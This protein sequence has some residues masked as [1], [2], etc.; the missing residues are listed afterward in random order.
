[1]M[2]CP[3][4]FN[5][6]FQELLNIPGPSMVS[7][8]ST[9]TSDLT[10]MVCQR[11][12]LVCA[13][14]M[15]TMSLS[16]FYKEDYSFNT[17]NNGEEYI[18]ITEDSAKGRAELLIDS[19]LSPN[20]D[21]AEA[22][23]VLEIGCGKGSFMR[24]L[25]DRFPH[26]QIWG[27]E[28]S[29]KASQLATTAGLQVVN[30]FLDE[31][32]L[33]GYQFDIVLAVGVLEHIPKP[34]IFLKNCARLCRSGGQV[35]IMI[36][37]SARISYDIFFV[38]HLFHFAPF[39][40]ATFMERAD[41]PVEV[42]MTDEPPVP[43]FLLAVGS[44]GAMPSQAYPINTSKV[45]ESV[46]FYLKVFEFLNEYSSSMVQQKIGIYGVNEV[47]TLFRTYSPDF[48]SLSV[49]VYIDDSPI[50]QGKRLDKKPIR[51]LCEISLNDLGAIVITT[52][53]RYYGSLETKLRSKGFKGK[54]VFPMKLSVKEL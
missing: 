47:F 28:P 52:N 45:A 44:K 42:I 29:I 31:Q 1:M 53:Q 50:L 30:G 8:Q 37:N 32:I 21:F 12:E 51:P 35:G 3:Y 36:P 34:D 33:K 38:D 16:T 25:K 46:S 23:S 6:S 24:V 49:D 26:L 5:K 18:F 10:K 20:L 11:C 54:L 22:E 14:K 40:I 41:I 48:R 2:E 19:W 17:Q 4:C 27:I 39:H 13:Q 15:D 43:Q 7:D 9:V